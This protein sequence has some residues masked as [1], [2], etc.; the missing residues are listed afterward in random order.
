MPLSDET[1]AVEIPIEGVLDLHTFSP[2]DAGAVVGDYL[3][4]CRQRQIYEVKIIHG[5]GRGVLLQT[6]HAV[7]RRH[8]LVADFRLDREGSGWGAT[9]VTLLRDRG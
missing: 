1:D 4:A 5:K 3:E 9:V 8:P 2:G 6:V 7:L